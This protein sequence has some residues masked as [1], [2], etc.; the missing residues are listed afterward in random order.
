VQWETD[1]GQRGPS[2]SFPAA[3]RVVPGIFQD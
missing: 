1:Y 2:G 3:V